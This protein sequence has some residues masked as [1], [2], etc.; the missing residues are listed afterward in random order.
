L[1][2]LA[3][4][5]LAF[6]FAIEARLWRP[7]D[8]L[9]AGMNFQVAEAQAWLDGRLDLEERQRDT[10]LYDARIYNAFPPGFTMLALAALPWSP[11]GVPHL[12]IV[13]LLVLPLPG[14]AYLLFLKR[15]GQ[16]WTATLL[17][18][19][20]LVGTS[21]LPVASIGVR[22]GFEWHLNH[23]L[24]QVGLL[25]F[26]LDYWCWKRLWPGGIGLALA[27]WSRQ[28]T[29][30]YAVPFV[31]LAVTAGP[32]D[33]RRGRVVLAVGL[34]AAMLALPAALNTVKFGSPAESGYRYIYE[35]RRDRFAQDAQQGLFSPGFI[36]RNLYYMNVGPPRFVEV[37]GRWHWVPSIEATG[38]WWSSPILL[39]LVPLA[40]RVWRT[41]EGQAALAAIALIWAGLLCYHGTGAE[42][43]GFNRF[44]L[45]YVL[46]MLTLIAPYCPQSWY[47][48][49]TPLAVSWSIV[50]FKWI[51]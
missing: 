11:A 32:A 38:I 21:L 23:L 40:R 48:W 26:L 2:G 43:R 41:G 34:V 46:M 31:W 10:A 13:A 8:V 16:V 1:A 35:G 44:S 14:L 7:G 5:Y 36:P 37:D 45:D 29:L 24:S 19:G 18:L 3:A 30:A 39:F 49:A 22:S 17:T 6:L 47:R 15:C 9:H 12:L 27:F 50:Y 33:G 4:C 20:Y 42:Q 28:L 25:V 51:L